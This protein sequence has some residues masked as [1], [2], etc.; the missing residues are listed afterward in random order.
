VTVQ[1]V[2]LLLLVMT[3][4]YPPR[5]PLWT[6]WVPVVLRTRTVVDHDEGSRSSEELRRRDYDYDNSGG[7]PGGA[8]QV[9]VQVQV[10]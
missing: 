10:H 5:L 7:G 2:V 8:D 1:M 6:L 4:P 9:R 3:I